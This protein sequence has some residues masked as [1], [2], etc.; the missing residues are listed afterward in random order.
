MKPVGK[1]YKLVVWLDIKHL[2]DVDYY[3]TKLPNPTLTNTK[4]G[5]VLLNRQTLAENLTHKQ[6]LDIVKFYG[7][8]LKENDE[9]Y[10]YKEYLYKDAGIC[11]TCVEC[12]VKNG[13]SMK[14]FNFFGRNGREL[15]Q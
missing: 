4:A 15:W 12:Y 5:R 10:L 8:I 7:N 2:G 1:K 3:K 13:K 11:D 14:Q 6:A 9:I